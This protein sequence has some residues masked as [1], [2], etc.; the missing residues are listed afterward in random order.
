[1]RGAPAVA[2]GAARTVR[3]I[4]IAV[5]RCAGHRSVHTPRTGCPSVPG[6]PRVTDCRPSY[7]LGYGVTA[8]DRAEG[9]AAWA[10]DVHTDRPLGLSTRVGERW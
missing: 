6:G 2:I 9:S 1:M 5:T 4:D 3:T 7:S 8:G 10:T